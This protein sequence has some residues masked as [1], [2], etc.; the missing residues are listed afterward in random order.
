MG[1]A[2]AGLDLPDYGAACFPSALHPPLLFPPPRANV[3]L[4]F[5]AL[6]VEGGWEMRLIGHTAILPR[7][8]HAVLVRFLHI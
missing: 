2:K 5:E 8:G 4:D 3:G 1:Q 7:N 6:G